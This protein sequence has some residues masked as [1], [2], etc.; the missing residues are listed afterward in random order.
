MNELLKLTQSLVSSFLAPGSEP[1]PSLE[2]SLFTQV[3]SSPYSSFSSPPKTG[4]DSPPP[5]EALTTLALNMHLLIGFPYQLEETTPIPTAYWK[6]RL[7]KITELM[8]KRAWVR[9][10]S[11]CSQSL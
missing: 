3:R 11:V 2:S 1:Y 7:S 6:L 5:K 10:Q 9:I 8:Q 4:K